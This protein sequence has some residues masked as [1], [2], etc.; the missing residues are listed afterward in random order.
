MLSIVSPSLIGLLFLKIYDADLEEE[1]GISYPL[2]EEDESTYLSE[3]KAVLAFD[4]GK[5]T[6]APFSECTI[7]KKTQSNTGSI[8][9][10]SPSA[11]SR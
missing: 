6:V 9:D 3:N 4:V 1:W 10:F 11:V 8:P 7:P 2:P 5:M